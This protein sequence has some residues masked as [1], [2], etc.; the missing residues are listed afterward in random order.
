MPGKYQQPE[1]IK[2]IVDKIG[3]RDWIL[4]SIQRKFVWDAERIVNLF[5]S[6]MQGYPIGTLMV[7]KL[8][9]KV[10]IKKLGFYDFLQD[11]QEKWRESCNDYK[12][13]SPV[14]YSVIDGQQRL[15]SIY[16]GVKGSYAERL[17]KRRWKNAY[18][19]TIQPKKVLYLNLVEKNADEDNNRLYDF[20][21][22]SDDEFNSK[23]NKNHW[24]RVS[25]IL[26]FP[27][28][29]E[30]RLD[31]DDF[32][33]YI[34]DVVRRLG[35]EEDSVKE[36]CKTLKKLYKMIFITQV[37]NY[38]L[39]E[40]NELDRVVDIFVRT[41]NGGVPLSFS[42]LVMSVIVSKWS[43]ARTKMDELVSLIKVDT[44]VNITRDFILKVFLYLYSEDIKFRIANLSDDLVKIIKEKLEET[45][46]LIKSVCI[47][48]KQTGLND[49][50]IRAKYALL[51]LIYY[52]HKNNIELNNVAKNADAR[53]TCGVFLK[54]SLIK[55]L[56]GG[57][58]DSVLI[59]I[60]RIIKNS[61]QEFPM[62][63]I[64]DELLGRPRNL[65]LTD[66][67]ID[68]LVKDASWGTNEARLLLSIITEI[69]PEYSYEHVDHLYPKSMFSTKELEKLE[70]LK[71]NQELYKFYS[72]KKNWNTL[73]NLQLL[74]SAE[75][76]S[77]NHEKLSSWF[78]RKPEY[79]QS[80]ML[81]K[82]DKGNDIFEDERFKDFV[83]ERRKLLISKLKEKITF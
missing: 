51:P 56:F 29:D 68:Q 4:P 71:N 57:S 66:E 23:A 26:D 35:I 39:E 36:A 58:P 60:R 77:K 18:D 30:S 50:T 17:P 28:Y 13:T 72:D 9:D 7:W 80:A 70:F 75:N 73:G 42:D 52:S 83:L 8:C 5:D 82:D 67:E 21:F 46:E 12:P 20:A 15:N 33:E 48:T 44:G 34:D 27:Y 16:I 53:R 54:L 47:F 32:I 59:P 40:D 61:K 11:Y 31:D 62:K 65:T 22:L 2:T 63:E 24:F 49:E 19:P 38:Y 25:D 6:I 43:D 76:E 64:R 37:I 55:G 78:T 81:P 45:G 69:N 3:S 14:V 10:T 74:N 1:T 41:N 79:R